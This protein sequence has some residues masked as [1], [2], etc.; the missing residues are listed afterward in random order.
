MVNIEELKQEYTRYFE[1]VPIQKYAAMAI[2]RDEDTIIRCVSRFN[3]VGQAKRYS[4]M[5]GAT[6]VRQVYTA[7]ARYG[8]DR[9]MVVT[10]NIFSRPAKILAQDTNCILVDRDVLSEWVLA[11]R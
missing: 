1:D 7:L 3:L 8:C 6:A 9:A 11:G 2:G 10:N 5:V 4:N